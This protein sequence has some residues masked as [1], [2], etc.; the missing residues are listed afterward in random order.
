MKRMG[1]EGDVRPWATLVIRRVGQVGNV[2]Y[3][4]GQRPKPRAEGKGR[5]ATQHSTAQHNGHFLPFPYINKLTDMHVPPGAFPRLG[6][7]WS[8]STEFNSH[9]T[10]ETRNPRSRP[11]VPPLFVGLSHKALTLLYPYRIQYNL[12][13]RSLLTQPRSSGNGRR[14]VVKGGGQGFLFSL[15]S[16]FPTA[17]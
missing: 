7:G 14:G 11:F 5:G 3:P 2:P 17:T 6:K 10:K 8:T 9:A 13:T 1:R 15:S 16:S 4:Q 12:L